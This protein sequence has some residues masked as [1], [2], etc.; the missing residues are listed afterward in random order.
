MQN[1]GLHRSL[2]KSRG[3]GAKPPSVY[4]QSLLGAWS[5]EQHA[6]TAAPATIVRRRL[7]MSHPLL[8]SHP[9]GLFSCLSR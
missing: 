3:F 7:S 4:G 5:G 9:C 6:D 8:P 2:G 1:P